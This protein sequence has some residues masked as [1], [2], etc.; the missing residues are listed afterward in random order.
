MYRVLSADINRRKNCLGWAVFYGNI[1]AFNGR[2]PENSRPFSTFLNADRGRGKGD[3]TGN[4]E[5]GRI[6]WD[7]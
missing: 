7:T 4:R 2:T 6:V 3:S 5:L 1:W